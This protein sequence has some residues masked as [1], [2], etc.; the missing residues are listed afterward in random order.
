MAQ[1]VEGTR[2][3]AQVRTRGRAARVV[4]RVF[5]ATAE[6]LSRVGFQAM[7][8]E[9]VAARSGVNKTTIYR[10]WPTKAELVAATMAEHGKQRIAID[11]G[12]LR[13]DLRAS[14]LMPFRLERSEQGMLRIMQMERSVPEVEAL[15]RRFRAA[16]ESLR[17]DMVRRGIARG[18]L[19]KHVDA[20]L[21]VDLVSAPMQRALLFNETVEESYVDRVLDV[22]LAGAAAC[23]AKAQPVS[24]RAGGR[25]EVERRRPR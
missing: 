5:S 25:R 8:V 24:R 2:R 3:T 16:L 17:L 4:E 23:A 1:N 15:A 20:Q 21:I 10:R 7:R 14:L 12:S 11:T 9:D 19:P 22:V 13:G 18:E 6:E